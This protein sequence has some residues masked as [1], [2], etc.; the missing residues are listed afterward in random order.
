MNRIRLF[1][2]AILLGVSMICLFIVPYSLPQNKQ[3]AIGELNEEALKVFI[4][5]IVDMDYIRTEIPF[6]NYVRDRKEADLHIMATTLSTGS[7]GGEY[8]IEF[9]GQ[10]DLT[11]MRYTLKHYSYQTDVWEEIRSGLVHIL[12]IGMAPFIAK[13]PFSDSISISFKKKIKPKVIEDKWDFWVFNAGLQGSRT[14]EKKVNSTMISG[15]FSANRVT[16][17]SKIRMGISGNYSESNFDLGDVKISSSL[18]SV[19]FNGLFVKS[20][21]DHWSVGTWASLSSASY[22]NIKYSFKPALAIEFSAIPYSES[23]RR[24]ITFLYKFGYNSIKYREE[25][26]Y[27]KI[28]DKLLNGSLTA[29]LELKEPWGF[30][31]TSFEASHY[32]HDFGKNRLQIYGSLSLR[33]VRGLS[34]RVSGGYSAIRDQLSLP[35]GKASL[36]EILLMRRELETNYSYH[37]SIG[38]SYSFGSI[39]SNVVNPRFGR[40]SIY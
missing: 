3:A 2:A 12:K 13:T 10:K 25:T 34:F 19:S 18:D 15:N 38:L 28:S 29:A 7:G 16:P 20:I 32:F 17:E 30:A 39:F 37:F 6:V 11:D 36:E 31:S 9:I 4:Q 35:R 26:I 21:S 14:G 1:Y 27:E 22:G 8:T 24:S 23:T 40:A 33:L 5:G